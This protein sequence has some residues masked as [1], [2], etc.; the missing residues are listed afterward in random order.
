M[1]VTECFQTMT[2]TANPLI[3]AF[4]K[5]FTSNWIPGSYHNLNTKYVNADYITFP[6]SAIDQ[7][8]LQHDSLFDFL[9]NSK[10]KMALFSGSSV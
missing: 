8:T 3:T 4:H 10:R 7:V 1:S 2:Q 5:C 6:S 9:I